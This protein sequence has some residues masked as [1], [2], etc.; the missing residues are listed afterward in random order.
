M[1]EDAMMEGGDKLVA[2]ESHAGDVVGC[3]LCVDTI[4]VIVAI[5]DGEASED[6]GTPWGCA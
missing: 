2:E 5:T 3:L 1:A 6:G 4:F